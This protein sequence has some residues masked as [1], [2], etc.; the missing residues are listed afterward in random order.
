MKYR[1][2][3]RCITV[4]IFLAVHA[5]AQTAAGSPV[6][7]SQPI[8]FKQFPQKAAC[9]ITSLE[10]IFLS[11]DAISIQLTP[12]FLLSGK[13]ISH[14]KPNPFAETVNITLPDFH[15]AIFT[16]SRI[17][18]ETGEIRFTGHIL[19][20][21]SRDAIVLQEENKKYSFIK[22]EQRFLMTE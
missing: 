17:T 9:D 20:F 7:F 8:L 5:N 14:K 21:E 16:I 19:N 4:F 11:V 15:E 2:I 1:K 10:Q 18:S 22:T 12:D 6:I 3:F 13:I